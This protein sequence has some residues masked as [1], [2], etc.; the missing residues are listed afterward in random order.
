M[1]VHRYQVAIE[2]TLSAGLQK[3]ETET[4]D[5]VLLDLSLPDSFGTETVTA[6][7]TRLKWTPIIVLT[8][9]QD[10]ELAVEAL[11]AGAQ[12]Y[13][14]KNDAQPDI[15]DR[16]IRY[17]IERSRADR[18]LKERLNFEEALFSSVPSPLYVKGTDNRFLA[19]NDAFAS[20]VGR[21]RD[22]IIGLKADEIPS[23]FRADIDPGEAFLPEQGRVASYE[24]DLRLPDGAKRSVFINK[25]S[26]VG[27]GGSVQGVIGVVTDVTEMK[28]KEGQLRENELRLTQYISELERSRRNLQ[29]Q[30]DRLAQLTEEYAI[31]KE[32]ALAADRSKSEF[33]AT[34]SH[35]IRTPLTGVLGMAD[36]LLDMRLDRTAD[37]YVRTIRESG[38]MLLSILNDILDMSRLEA[39]RLEL[40]FINF[41]LHRMIRDLWSLMMP[42]AR[43]KDVDLEIKIQSD[44]PMAINADPVRIRQILF[45]LIGNA[46]KFT[47]RGHI[48]VR[49]Q[50]AEFHA[51]GIVI[52][53]EVQDTGIGI[54]EH[55]RGNLFKRFSQADPST[56][57]QFGGSGL[58]LAI[59]RHLAEMMGGEIGFDSEVNQGSTFWFTVPCAE[60]SGEVVDPRRDEKFLYRAARPLRIL[61]AED[62]QIN[63]MLIMTQLTR[64][65]HHV[66]LASNG[67]QALDWITNEGD[68]F[69]LVL[70]DVR[71]PEM[72]GPDTT[73]AVR[74]LP[75]GRGRIPV[76]AVTADAME[77]HIDTYREAGHGCLRPQADRCRRVAGNHQQ[78]A[79]RNRPRA[80]TERPCRRRANRASAL[81]I[82][83]AAG[84]GGRTGQVLLRA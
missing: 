24:T 13:L 57:R 72:D 20:M 83:A 75:D 46:I 48:T 80:G 34:M 82:G 6:A 47:H 56:T 61:V 14:V 58:G 23:F 42:K 63:Q 21:P 54:P 76:V 59:C 67:V 49:V 7:R 77:N 17:A 55:V 29:E 62:N 71:M 3:A 19:C 28:E 18:T 35:E 44:V 41:D 79:R 84:C 4:F 37:G 65:G 2:G 68:R 31:E 81:R 38:E 8:G 32:K 45:N 66:V 78:R 10:Q 51:D 15:L 74:R 64:L 60:V 16:T 26:F 5:I 73:R 36:L 52:R 25:A 70:M 53:Y 50:V 43:V 9:N 69:D 12:D 30:T 22:E 1:P 33:L 27:V 11:R 40:E 39:G